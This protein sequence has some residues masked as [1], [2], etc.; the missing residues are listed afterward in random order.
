[1][2]GTIAMFSSEQYYYV[3]IN[4][5]FKES[6]NSTIAELV[7]TFKQNSL[8]VFELAVESYRSMERNTQGLS[9]N[10]VALEKWR[11]LNRLHDRNETLYYR[12]SPLMS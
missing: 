6:S 1:M 9:E 10:A 11:V 7:L 4:P 12:V 5:W 8:W 2:N 3:F